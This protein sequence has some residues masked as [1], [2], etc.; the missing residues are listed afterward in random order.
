MSLGYALALAEARS[1]AAATAPGV[2]A[3]GA[4]IGSA[5][6]VA[7]TCGVLQP[8]AAAPEESRTVVHLGGVTFGVTVGA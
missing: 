2:G 8:D 4:P 1:R 3:P 6:G 7:Y 5:L